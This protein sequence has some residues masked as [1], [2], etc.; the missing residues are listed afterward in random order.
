VY[1]QKEIKALKPGPSG[2]R[3]RAFSIGRLDRLAAN[4]PLQFPNSHCC[5]NQ[6]SRSFRAALS[7][8]VFLHDDV[9]TGL[10]GHD[11]VGGGA[12]LSRWAL[13][14]VLSI[15]LRRLHCPGMKNHKNQTFASSCSKSSRTK[16]LLP[17]S[18]I[19]PSYRINCWPPDCRR[20]RYSKGA[21]GIPNSD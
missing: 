11:P 3:S 10:L 18:K 1:S 20:R 19:L 9:S 2:E 14:T 6:T 7:L 13:C 16:V 8:D 5:Q 4:A 12:E 15:D 21:F 17:G